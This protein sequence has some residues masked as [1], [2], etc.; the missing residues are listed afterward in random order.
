M[1]SVCRFVLP[2]GKFK[3][4]DDNYEI[5]L[6]SITITLGTLGPLTSALA[7]VLEELQKSGK[8]YDI[9]HFFAEFIKEIPQFAGG[10]QQ[11][12]HEFLRH[13]LEIV[14]Y[15]FYLLF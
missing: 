6:P 1:T 10:F 4:Y 5:D 9:K 13:L 7:K 14:R 2:G 11:D 3:P 12:C 8:I 15:V